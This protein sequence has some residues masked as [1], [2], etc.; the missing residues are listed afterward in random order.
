MRATLQ[1]TPNSSTILNGKPLSPSRQF[2]DAFPALNAPVNRYLQ[3]REGLRTRQQVTPL[4]GRNSNS[5]ATPPKN[6]TSQRQQLLF[7]LEAV[8]EYINP[9]SILTGVTPS[10]TPWVTL[11]LSAMPNK[12]LLV[13]GWRSLGKPDHED[14]AADSLHGPLELVSGSITFS[15]AASITPLLQKNYGNSSIPRLSK[16]VERI[17]AASSADLTVRTM[18]NYVQQTNVPIFNYNQPATENKA[19]NVRASG[20][21]GDFLFPQIAYNQFIPLLSLHG[22]ENTEYGIS[23]GVRKSSTSWCCDLLLHRVHCAEPEIYLVDWVL[24]LRTAYGAC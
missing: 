16:C 3:L 10:L 4:S 22:P 15:G 18:L 2:N 14:A 5:R 6:E 20:W 23:C 7:N 9:L 13:S 11:T 12:T 21:H 17:G 8:C 19:E 24:H 1:T